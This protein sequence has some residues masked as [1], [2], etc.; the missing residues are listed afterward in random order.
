VSAKIANTAGAEEEVTVGALTQEGRT[1]L[2]VTI[3]DN[4]RWTQINTDKRRIRL[5]SG[6]RAALDSPG[7]TGQQAHEQEPEESHPGNINSAGGV[8]KG[9]T[10]LLCLWLV[11]LRNH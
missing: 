6:R 9:E 4:H 10:R 11:S 1:A 7:A 3:H 5:G 8:E 2:A